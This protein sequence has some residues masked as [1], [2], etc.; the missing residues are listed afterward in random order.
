M[1]D[2]ENPE[3]WIP[4]KEVAVYSDPNRCYQIARKYGKRL[5][6]IRYEGTFIGAP[7]YVCVFASNRGENGE[8]SINLE[9]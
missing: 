2:N 4:G 9:S 7:V 8:R 1:I 6:E 3:G 5:V